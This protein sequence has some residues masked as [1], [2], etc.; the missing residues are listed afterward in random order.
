MIFFRFTIYSHH[1]DPKYPEREFNHA[2]PQ[3]CKFLH[4]DIA[5]AN[6]FFLFPAK[7]HDTNLKEASVIYL[8]L[9]TCAS[10]I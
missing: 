5:L 8:I 4:T 9:G 3:S 7:C 6:V 2:L 1:K 10:A